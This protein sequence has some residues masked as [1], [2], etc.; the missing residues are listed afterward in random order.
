MVKLNIA[1]RC[2]CGETDGTEREIHG[3]ETVECDGCGIV[4]QPLDYD[5]DGLR[6]WYAETYYG[7]DVY[8]HSYSH[9]LGVAVKRIYAYGL[10]DGVEILDVGAGNGAFVDAA[11]ASGYRAKGQDLA[12]QSEAPDV[13][14]GPLAEIAFP[15]DSFDV[16][17]LHDV[18]EHAADPRALLR[19]IRRVLSDDGLL[20]VDFPNFWVEEGRH[21]WK[22]IEHLWMLSAR[23]LGRLLE[24]EGFDVVEV[25]APIPSKT[26]VRAR[27]KPVERTTFLVPPGI[28]DGYWC[29]V[30]LRGFC[31]AHD[32]TL[33]VTVQVHD[34]GPRRSEEF[35][36]RIPF[37]RWGGYRKLDA[38]SEKHAGRIYRNGLTAVYREFG[39]VD[40]F[41]TFNAALDAGLSLD[42]AL[43]GPRSE[44]RHPFF[45]PKEELDAARRDRAL[46]GPYIVT[47]WWEKGFYRRWLDQFGEGAI[48]RTLRILADAGFSIVVTGA[49]WDEGGIASRIAAADP[50]FEDRVGKTTLGEYL[51]LVAGA[52]AVFGFPAGTTMLGPFYEVPTVLL[53]ESRFPRAMWTNSVAPDPRYRAHDVKGLNPIAAAAAVADV[54]RDRKRWEAVGDARPRH[55]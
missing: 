27:A 35:W 9:D 54:A 22:P 33:P 7:E 38:E 3:I 6:A 53:W 13:Y 44:W 48:V 2:L 11:N 15:T 19:E 20:I 52:D 18:L 31:E 5:E 36:R 37:V 4:R 10:P 50:R 41:M 51:A 26:V 16:V 25:Q 40:Y 28:G 34:S 21:H 47:A 55:A 42:D 23:Q 49:S 29:A 46:R 32:I 43:P 8:T 1:E 24:E 17:T 39:G 14:V 30:K 45:R 12:E